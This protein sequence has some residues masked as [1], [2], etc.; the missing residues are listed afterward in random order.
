ML[1]K[2]SLFRALPR[3]RTDTRGAR[4][5]AEE[6]QL[7]RF[8]KQQLKIHCGVVRPSVSPAISFGIL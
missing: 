5:E 3:T 2:V 1:H 6:T 7:K 4:T 8:E